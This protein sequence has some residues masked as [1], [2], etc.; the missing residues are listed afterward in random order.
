AASEDTS[1]LYISMWALPE[2]IE[3]A[4]R[5]GDT[6]IAGGALARLA[7]FTTAAGTDFGLGIEARSRA[8]LSAGETAE[9]LYR[10]AIERLGRTRL[11]PAPRRPHQLSGGRLQRGEPRT[12][13]R[14]RMGGA[15]G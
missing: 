8:L 10:E 13:A 2:L 4:A 7:E 9:N 15:H 12:R 11:R 3:A 14:G 6:G 5:T 1:T